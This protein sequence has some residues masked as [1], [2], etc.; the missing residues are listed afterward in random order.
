M[1]KHLLLFTALLLVSVSFMHAQVNRH[2]LFEHFT[3]AS[4]APCA[5]Q[6]PVFDTAIL[7]KNLYYVKHVAFHT[8]WPGTDPMNAYN[9]SDVDGRVQYYGVGGVPNMHML[10]T[11]FVGSPAYATFPMAR[12]AAMEASPLEVRVIEKT[13]G[14]TRQVQVIV[15]SLVPMVAGT[16]KVRAA[17]IESE[18]DYGSPP[19]SNGETHFPNVMRK[20]IPSTTGDNFTPAALHPDSVVFNYTYNLDLVNWDTSKIYTIAWVQNDDTEEVINC[21]SARD[22]QTGWRIATDDE[23]IKVGNT[24][25]TSSFISTLY[26]YS[27]NIKNFRIIITASQP[28]G[29]T[30]LYGTDVTSITDSIDVGVQDHDQ[31]GFYVKA[32]PGTAAFIGEYIIT[33]KDL[34]NAS[35]LPLKIRYLV[36]S[37]I[38]DLIVNNDAAWGDGGTTKASDFQENYIEGLEFAGNTSFSVAGSMNFS[39][40]C[41]YDKLGDIEHVY[42]NVG[43]SFPSFTNENVT[44]FKKVLDAG[45]NFLVSGQDVGWDTWDVNNGGNGTPETQAFY[46]NYLRAS[47][48]NDGG[49]TNDSIKPVS[50]ENVFINL[51]KSKLINPY[52]SGTSGAYFYPDQINPTTTGDKILTYTNATKN[53][54]VRSKIGG[55]Y[56][57]VNLG[58]SI[59]MVEDSIVR[60]T[61]LKLAHD[62]FHGFIDGIE[63]DQAINS[64]LIGQ[65]YPNPATENTFIP[66]YEMNADALLLITD[67]SGKL[68]CSQI[69]AKGSPYA[70]VNVSEWPSGIYLYNLMLDGKNVKGNKI[71]VVR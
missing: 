35:A 39:K 49:A 37:G 70:K 33:V 52:G 19:G 8:S 17:V 14:T 26:N 2:V 57:T 41:Q 28:A 62:W 1:K 63:F 21:G 34:D 60:K 31:L 7:A 65:P 68:V 29:W 9:A 25:D 23:P 66:L 69:V 64:M 3:N 15:Y 5:Q 10:G 13:V 20:L 51:N 42:F 6:N 59:E 47:F 16:Y 55:T 71:Q 61:I 24:G 40:I 22:V 12:D 18:I 50:A 53:G 38:T 36:N 58:F 11:L 4:C 30:G 46:T 48:V 27:D 45:G 43:W 67:I 44:A 32:V 54:A 56:K